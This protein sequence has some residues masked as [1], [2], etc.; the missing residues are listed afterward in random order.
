MGLT[1]TV[2]FTVVCIDIL[3]LQA[4]LFRPLWADQCSTEY[5]EFT[6]GSWCTGPT[7]AGME[8]STKIS[9][10]SVILQ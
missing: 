3:R 2:D 4:V 6:V 5:P 8:R 7:E 9:Q 10:G 1:A